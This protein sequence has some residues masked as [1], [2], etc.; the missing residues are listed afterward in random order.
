[1]FKSTTRFTRHF[2]QTYTANCKIYCKWFN[3]INK[4]LYSAICSTLEKLPPF[5][6]LHRSDWV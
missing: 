5:W 1:M 3:T 6:T 2:T 4:P